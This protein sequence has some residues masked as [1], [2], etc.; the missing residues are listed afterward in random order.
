M[1]WWLQEQKILEKIR[2]LSDFSAR[3]TSVL[4][5]ALISADLQRGSN[6]HSPQAIEQ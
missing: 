6:T 4:D 1:V 3:T 5:C 2:P